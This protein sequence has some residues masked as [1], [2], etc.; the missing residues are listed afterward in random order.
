MANSLSLNIKIDSNIEIHLKDVIILL[1]NAGWNI[2]REGKITLLPLHDNDMF[3]WVQSDISM[4]D[5]MLLVDQKE[6]LKELVGVEL[7][8]LNTEI[9]GKILLYN[10][11]DF[12]FQLNINPQYI[13]NDLK[14][15]DFNWY[16]EKIFAVLK[17]KYHIAEYSYSFTY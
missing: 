8:W 4:N 2:M 15:P 11:V 10:R 14:I 12:S 1:M 6:A 3:D 13:Q 7:F 16:A 5:F 9:G 17:R